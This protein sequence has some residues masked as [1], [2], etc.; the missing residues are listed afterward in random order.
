MPTLFGNVHHQSLLRIQR[1][2]SS[3]RCWLNNDEIPI[4]SDVDGLDYLNRLALLRISVKLKLRVF[5]SKMDTEDKPMLDIAVASKRLAEAIYLPSTLKMPNLREDGNLCL[6]PLSHNY[7][8]S[9]IRAAPSIVF[10]PQMKH[11]TLIPFHFQAL[12]YLDKDQADD[13]IQRTCAQVAAA[14]FQEAAE[15]LQQWMSAT[16]NVP[17]G[18]VLAHY[19]LPGQTIPLTALQPIPTNASDSDESNPLLQ[20]WRRQLHNATS[21]PLDRPLF[22]LAQRHRFGTISMFRVLATLIY[23]C[24]ANMACPLEC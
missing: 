22:R 5:Q 21:Q 6:A 10:K 12:L 15:S 8:T 3:L 19:Q 13:C 7:P 23:L 9:G 4:L 2:E 18:A 16:G 17:T 14:R 20:N 24:V 11:Y 1:C